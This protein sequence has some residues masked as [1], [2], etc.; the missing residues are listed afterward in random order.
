[1]PDIIEELLHLGEKAFEGALKS[2]RD[3][4]RHARALMQDML[5]HCD[6]VTREE[7]DSAI[8]RVNKARLI[9]E[10]LLER[11]RIMESRLGMSR[12]K[13][14]QIKIPGK[15][16]TPPKPSLPS[17]KHDKRRRRR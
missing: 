8:A 10:E 15:K 9:Q 3:W 4:K 12:Q 1:M 13:K 2:R 5:N 16:I 11:M 6:I 7:F 17:V 14:P